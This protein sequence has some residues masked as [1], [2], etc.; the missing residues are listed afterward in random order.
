M[1]KHLEY[2]CIMWCRLDFDDN[3]DMLEV[4][5]L[6]KDGFPPL[7]I[8]YESDFIRNVRW[9]VINDTEEFIHPEDNDNHSTIILYDDDGNLICTNKNIDEV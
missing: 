5:K 3:V 4:E 7:E 9:S 1:G 8:G 2:K 6:I